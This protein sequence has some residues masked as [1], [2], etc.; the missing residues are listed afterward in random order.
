VHTGSFDALSPDAAMRAVEDAHGITLDGTLEVYNSYVNRVY[1]MR[2]EDGAR[3]VAKFYRPGRW[4]GDAIRDEHR[5]L[6]DCAEAEIPVVAPL[7]GADGET[8]HRTVLRAE[9]SAPGAPGMARGPALRAPGAPGTVFFALFPRMGGRTFELES[10]DDYQRL[11][12]LMGRCHFVGARR[13]APHRETCRPDTLTALYVEELLD[14]AVHPDCAE[15]FRSV[16]GEV[17]KTI[18]P[19]FDGVA[20]HRIHGDCHRGNVIDR[21]SA[22]AIFGAASGP[23]A[24]LALIDFDD[25]M[26]GPAVQDLWLILPDHAEKSARELAL[27]LDGYEQFMG[28]ERGTLRLI[29]PLRFMRMI[30]FLTWTA[31]QRNDAWFRG[32]NPDW[33]TKSFWIRETRDL[34][35]QAQLIGESLG[36]A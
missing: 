22:V 7:A 23:G 17:L 13:D 24:G 31:R 15:G 2:G 27:L 28:F 5:F 3:Y 8:L 16:C 6:K 14:G 9:A 4:D 18:T 25:M 19:L 29:E 30:Y 12:A 33:G 26:R 20:L 21:P 36:P 10:D 1:G 35:E 32:A 11:G 34:I